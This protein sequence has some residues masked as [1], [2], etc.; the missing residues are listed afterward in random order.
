M[1]RSQIPAFSGS[2]DE[3]SILFMST[4]T[5]SRGQ[6]ITRAFIV[7]QPGPFGLDA[8]EGMPRAVCRTISDPIGWLRSTGLAGDAIST[9]TLAVPADAEV[10]IRE[11]L[12]EARSL[13]DISKQA[14]TED[15]NNR[16]NAW[17]ELATNW[18]VDAEDRPST[19]SLIR[20]QRFVN[21]ER[22]LLT[23][24]VPERTLIRPLAVIFPSTEK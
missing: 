18:E 11:G 22:E 12:R 13:T 9:G 23:A 15:A 6:V 5:N 20:S 2:I 7:A 8:P 16:T 19:M 10:L 1:E 3:L 4:L 21:Q 14:A 17:S 24:S